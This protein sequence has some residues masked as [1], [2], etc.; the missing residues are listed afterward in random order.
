MGVPGYIYW[1]SG[2]PVQGLRKYIMGVGEYICR[3]SQVHIH[4]LR[5]CLC[6]CCFRGVWVFRTPA[7]EGIKQT[8]DYFSIIYSDFCNYGF[9]ERIPSCSAVKNPSLP[10]P[11][12]S[13]KLGKWESGHYSRHGKCCHPRCALGS[14]CSGPHFLPYTLC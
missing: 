10:A 11:V 5:R 3:S 7:Y 9:P 12:S 2:V 6:G 8:A 13:A 14:L 1:S 4:V